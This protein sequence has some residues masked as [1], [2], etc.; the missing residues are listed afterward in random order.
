MCSVIF[1]NIL[2]LF[3]SPLIVTLYLLW[4]SMKVLEKKKEKKKMFRLLLVHRCVTKRASTSLNENLRMKGN[5]GLKARTTFFFHQKI[6]Y[7][8]ELG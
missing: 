3:A 2:A 8:Q 5:V 1:L 6:H 4:R 7:I